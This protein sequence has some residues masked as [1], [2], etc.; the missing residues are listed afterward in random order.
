MD[1]HIHRWF[2]AVIA[3]VMALWAWVGGLVEAA[4]LLLPPRSPVVGPARRERGPQTRVHGRVEGL[5]TGR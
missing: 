4:L 1:N 2:Y 3:T 5:T